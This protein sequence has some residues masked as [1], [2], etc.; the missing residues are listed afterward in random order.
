VI[1][2]CGLDCSECDIYK[3]S[4]EPSLARKIA[5]AI[6]RRGGKV[7]ADIIKCAGCRGERSQHWSGNC[8]LLNCC[9]DDKGHESCHEC[10]EFPCF[11]L[12]EWARRSA[13][14][15]EALRRLKGLRA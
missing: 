14:Y 15:G 9:V 12:E 7:S 11:Q 6:N 8:K 10:E 13:R 2:V 1:A 5:D 4:T 3:A